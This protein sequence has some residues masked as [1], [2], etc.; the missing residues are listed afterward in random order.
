MKIKLD[1]EKC[2][3]CGTC[4][5]IC[6]DIFK[7]G[8]D[9]KVHLKEAEAKGQKEEKEIEKSDCA[10]EAADSCAVQAIEIQK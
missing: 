5:S 8:D 1:L 2:I 9:M 7:L 6:S 3:G 4:E 10:E